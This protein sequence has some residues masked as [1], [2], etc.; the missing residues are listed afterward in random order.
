MQT[1]FLQR[2]YSHKGPGCGGGYVRYL[3]SD[4]NYDI[5][6]VYLALI[7]ADSASKGPE[8]C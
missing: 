5:I 3:P 7:K 1:T 6:W 4:I 2:M 8:L